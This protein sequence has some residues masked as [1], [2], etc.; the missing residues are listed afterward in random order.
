MAS[1][2]ETILPTT[3]IMDNSQSI[4]MHSRHI[5]QLRGSPAPFTLAKFA[6]KPIPNPN[7]DTITYIPL[8]SLLAGDIHKRNSYRITWVHTAQI[9]AGFRKEIPTEDDQSDA[10]FDDE[11][12]VYGAGPALRWVMKTPEQWKGLAA[13]TDL[14]RDEEDGE[15]LGTFPSYVQSIIRQLTSNLAKAVYVDD[16]MGVF[17]KSFYVILV[18]LVLVGCYTTITSFFMMLFP[19]KVVTEASFGR[20]GTFPK[21]Q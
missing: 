19:R 20:F 6:L 1:T 8:S 10:V 17:R 16:R 9:K 4:T 2:S 13:M 12:K 21:I 11:T 7:A 15:V 14:Q 18:L 3:T 5:I